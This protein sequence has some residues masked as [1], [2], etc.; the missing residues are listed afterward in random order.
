MKAMV[1]TETGKP[2]ERQEV[3][4]PQPEGNDVLIKIEA[5]AVCRTDL[6]V[7]DGELPG[8]KTPLIP[9]HEIVGVIEETGPKVTKFS[10]GDKVGVPWLGQTCMECEFCL[11]GR[12]NLCRSAEFTGYTINGGYADY[13]RADSRFIFH[14]PDNYPGVQA[15][16]LLC[17]GL[18]GYR[19]LVMAGRGKDIGFYGF[20]AAAHILIQVAR[21]QKRRVFAFTRPGDEESQEFAYTLGAQWA[22]DS[23]ASSPQPLDSAIIFAPLGHLVPLALKSVKPGGKVICAG[24]HMSD[25]PTFPYRLLWEERCINSVANLTRQDGEEFMQLAPKIPIETEVTE[26]ELEDANRA[27]ADLKNG[28]INGAAVLS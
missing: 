3:P 28:R 8:V 24:I 1:L 14:I 16:P 20:G 15:A 12:E 4:K 22:G 9:G 21:Y 18:I 6:H 10:K 11:D 7:V 23:T 25:I 26:Y 27:L 2:L 17:A 5:C 19:S 13:C